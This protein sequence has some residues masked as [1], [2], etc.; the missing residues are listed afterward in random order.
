[1]RGA[2]ISALFFYIW[3]KVVYNIVYAYMQLYIV[4]KI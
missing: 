2:E 3:K 1:M 4:G